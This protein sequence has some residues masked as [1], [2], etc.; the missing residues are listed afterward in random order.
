[1]QISVILPV[2]NGAKLLSEVI[3]SVQAQ[4]LGDWEMI[5]IDDGS[6]DSTSEVV[7]KAARSDARIR[8]FRNPRNLGLANT[9]N[10]ALFISQ[11]SFLAR[12]DG[13]D[14]LMPDRFERQLTFLERHKDIDIV[15]GAA[16]VSNET[17]HKRQ[18]RLA[19]RIAGI[20]DQIG[21][22]PIVFH[23]STLIRRSF[24]ERYGLY[25]SSLLRSQDREL[26][27]RA[28]QAGARFA[29]LQEPVIEYT[30]NGYRRSLRTISNKTSSAIRIGRRYDLK[31]YRSKA[32][33]GAIVMLLTR[34]GL[35]KPR[36]E[37]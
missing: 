11:G 37:R 20:N 30:S 10:R 1:M 32:L 34:F 15:G 35:Y 33:L 12:V 5:L 24:F 31:R 22:Q 19:E 9:L 23:S 26:W 3:A 27:I 13:D 7:E 29:N 25:D 2:Y 21:F 18:V 6:S 17:G 4:T 36:S 16:I 14:V 8:P 28:L